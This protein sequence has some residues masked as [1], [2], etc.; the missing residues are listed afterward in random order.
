ME[1]KGW[2]T[3]CKD[4]NIVIG[5]SYIKRYY[6]LLAHNYSRSEIKRLFKIRP[7]K[8]LIQEDI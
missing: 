4:T 2:V 6:P 1:V 3:I 7:C 8:I 5:F